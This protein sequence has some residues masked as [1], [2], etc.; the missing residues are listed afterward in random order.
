MK[1]LVPKDQVTLPDDLYCPYC[2]RDKFEIETGILA[3]FLL[4]R[5]VQVRC[6]NCQ[7]MSLVEA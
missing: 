3:H 1:E 5:I 7:M 2:A 6:K 4:G